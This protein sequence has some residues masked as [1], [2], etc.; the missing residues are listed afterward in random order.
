MVLHDSAS[1]T[2]VP[3]GSHSLKGK[4]SITPD[5]ERLVRNSLYAC[6]VG[7]KAPQSAHHFM[8]KGVL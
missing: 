3:G 5:M 7:S 6:H 1:A 8:L 4:L 2:F